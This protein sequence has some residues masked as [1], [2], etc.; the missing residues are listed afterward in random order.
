VLE[1]ASEPRNI[2]R[3]GLPPV[4]GADYLFFRRERAVS[5]SHFGI[6]AAFR[7]KIDVVG[8]AVDGAQQGPFGRRAGGDC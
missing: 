4:L 6:L 8:R 1:R 2:F 5:N 3:R 7:R